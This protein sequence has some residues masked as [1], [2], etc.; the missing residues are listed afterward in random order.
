MVMDCTHQVFLLSSFLQKRDSVL[1]FGSLMNMWS[2]IFSVFVMLVYVELFLYSVCIRRFPL[3]D[4][5]ILSL[6]IVKNK[7]SFLYF[8]C[9]NQ[10]FPFFLFKMHHRSE[11]F[12]LLS[13]QYSAFALHISSF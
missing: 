9:S 10:L 1:I 6:V 13:C 11:T 12:L 4:L 7:I 2:L 8:P 3:G 5:D